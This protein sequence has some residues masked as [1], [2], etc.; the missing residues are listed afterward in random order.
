MMVPLLC[1]FVIVPSFYNGAEKVGVPE[2]FMELDTAR[3]PADVS[4]FLCN[5]CLLHVSRQ[6]DR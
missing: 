1:S 5:S 3:L 6:Y 4:I 2:G